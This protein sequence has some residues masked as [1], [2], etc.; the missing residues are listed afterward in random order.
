MK[1]GLFGDSERQILT[2]DDSGELKQHAENGLNK[3]QSQ[4]LQS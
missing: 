1:N 4:L 3:R 2:G